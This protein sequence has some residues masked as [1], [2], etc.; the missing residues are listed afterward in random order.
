[1]KKATIICENIVYNK[2]GI[3]KQQ[4]DTNSAKVAKI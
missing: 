3:Y 4:K 1:M 2:D